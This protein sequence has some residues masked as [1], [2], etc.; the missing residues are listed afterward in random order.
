MPL[1]IAVTALWNDL[2][3]ARAEVLAEVDGI[4]QGQAD[5]KPGAKDWSLG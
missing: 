1:P 5:W 2:E 3:A 4:S